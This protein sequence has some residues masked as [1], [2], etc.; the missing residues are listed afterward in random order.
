MASIT[1]RKF[2]NGIIAAGLLCLVAGIVVVSLPVP[3]LPTD[4]RN[5]RALTDSEVPPQRAVNLAEP[6]PKITGGGGY[7][8]SNGCKECHP[9]EYASWH[10]TYHR[11]MTQVASPATVLGDFN[12]VR[13]SSRN[14]E[15][16]FQ[17]R[18]DEFWVT[19][20]DPDWEAEARSRGEHLRMINDPPMVTRRVVMTTGSH[21]MQGY[22]I[23]RE[24]GNELWQVPWWYLLGAQRWV[25]REDA[26]LEPPDGGR[27]LTMWNQVCIECHAVRGN[28]GLGSRIAG[29][30]HSSVAELGIAC[31]ACHG[32]GQKHV[33]RHRAAD[34]PGS[35]AQPPAEPNS[36]PD[37]TIFNPTRHAGLAASRVCAQC[38]SYHQFLDFQQFYRRGVHHRPGTPDDNRY[39]FAFADA[40]TRFPES[41]YW[42]SGFWKDGTAC[43]GGDEFQGL[44]GSAC[45]QAGDMSCISCHSLHHSDP[46][47]Q[48]LHGK[49]SNES[50]LQCHE[51]YRENLEQ[52]THHPAGSPGSLCYN[53]HM[54][55]TS[56][57]LL[58]ALR[59][60]RV[61]S[62]NAATSA[63]TGRP[64]ACNQ[65]H[66]DQ[67][68]EWTS[69]QLSRLYGHPPA[70]LTDPQR[71]VSAAVL[72]LLEG[73][74]LQR[75]LS[76]WTLGWPPAHQASGNDWQAPLLAHLLEDDYSAVRYIAGKS[77]TKLPEYHDL[78]YDFV[79]SDE[80]RRQVKDEAL[81]R[82]PSGA[83]A[84]PADKARRLLF[85]EQGRPRVLEM[86]KLLQSRD[87]TPIN[88]ME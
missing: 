74:A 86:E 72:W 34:R 12:D 39:E 68:L 5:P 11:T 41:E 4:K 85:D 36:A 78:Q 63:E 7:V 45:F 25:P 61:D 31:E 38:H 84:L 8:T 1:S 67:T 9:A 35:A 22:W 88:V 87:R 10:K 64:N 43:V 75:A 73:N 44:V 37:P 26:F 18:G 47:A 55:F 51:T 79:G 28:P 76:A 65:C 60:H 21:R 57:A 40:G 50:C 42:D 46:D 3:E 33:D 52:H 32:P 19:M 30:A 6:L 77:L 82:Y 53:C 81:R 17:R 13:L 49:Q 27:H 29:V 83:A 56:Y 66:I 15:Y 54:P 14:R 71:E 80:H 20:P 23:S 69:Q 59:S 16:H 70:K 24:K 62:P 2:R 48:L 58:S